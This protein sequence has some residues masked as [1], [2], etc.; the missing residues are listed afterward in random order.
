MG[1]FGHGIR[2]GQAMKSEGALR[3]EVH[4]WGP[5]T[6]L[7]SLQLNRESDN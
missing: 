3:R 4:T 7:M 1:L 5:G 6:E 2:T